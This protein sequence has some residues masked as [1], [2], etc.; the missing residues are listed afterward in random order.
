VLEG[1]FIW[2]WGGEG[3]VLYGDGSTDA[4]GHVYAFKYWLV[5]D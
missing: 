5:E 1:V 3:E 2:T 4:A